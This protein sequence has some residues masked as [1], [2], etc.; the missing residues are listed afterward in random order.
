VR[1]NES[2]VIAEKI[3]YYEYEGIDN[4][5]K[6]IDY[7]TIK[8]CKGSIRNRIRRS[9]NQEGKL[10]YDTEITLFADTKIKERSKIVHSGKNYEVKL[11]YREPNNLGCVYYYYLKAL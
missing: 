5:T 1:T 9:N 2:R 11:M 4:K 7:T 6:L 3:E 8:Y 10:N